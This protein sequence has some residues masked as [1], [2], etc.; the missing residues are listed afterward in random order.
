VNKG[1]LI[2]Q[3]R[4]RE[5]ARPQFDSALALLTHMRVE[6]PGLP[7][8]HGL[9][10]VTYAGLGQADEAVRA[11]KR[12]VEIL[13]LEVDA[14]EGPDYLIQLANVYL[15]LG[16]TQNAVACYDHIVSIPSWTSTN[17]L[18]VDPFLAPLRGTPEFE[19]L[20]AKWSRTGGATL[21]RPLPTSSCP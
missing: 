4:G 11:A 19:Q 5:A 16:Q 12:A 18:R 1:R 7:W 2:F 9:L 10:G 17:A 20:I 15:M 13:P 3:T 6:Q 8:I 21:D 14:L